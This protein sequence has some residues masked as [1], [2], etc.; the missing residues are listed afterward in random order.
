MPTDPADAYDA[1]AATYREDV[2]DS[3]YNAHLDVPGTTALLPDVAGAHVL[4]AGCGTGKYSAWLHDHGADV[5]GIDVSEEMVAHARERLP[6]TVPVM[7]ATLEAELPFED[8]AFDGVVS[9]L[10]LDYLPDWEP[11]FASFHRVLRPGGFLVFSVSH[12]FDEFPLADDENYFHREQRVK[13]WD[14][15]IPYYRR[16]LEAMVNP[17]LRAGF[18]LS[19]VTEPQPTEAFKAVMPDRYEK[20]SRHPVFLAMRATVPPTA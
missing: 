16:P 8:A 2:E 15:E 6:A 3:P 18:T 19:E 9:G 17:L 12:P 14:V 10:V 1:I 11:V 13:D 4:D 5:V 7:Q 20:E